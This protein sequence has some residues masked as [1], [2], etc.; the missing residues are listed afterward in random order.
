ML[1]LLRR[2][3]LT[4]KCILHTTPYMPEAEPR[5]GQAGAQS[6]ELVVVVVVAINSSSY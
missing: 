3:Y 6:M 2:Y 5:H 4:N 1:L